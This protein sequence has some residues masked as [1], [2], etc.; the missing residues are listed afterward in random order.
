MLAGHAGHPLR[1]IVVTQD[2]D[3]FQ[4]GVATAAPAASPASSRSAKARTSSSRAKASAS[5]TTRAAKSPSSSS[6]P[7]SS[8]LD[9]VKGNYISYDGLHENTRSPPG[10][11]PTAKGPAKAEGGRVRAIIQPKGKKRR[12]KKRRPADPEAHLRQP[13]RTRKAPCPTNSSSPNSAA[14]SA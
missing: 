6:A 4:K 5:S 9:E 2:A 12:T 10:S 13:C 7:G 1:R 14:A 11:Q 8:G 3:G